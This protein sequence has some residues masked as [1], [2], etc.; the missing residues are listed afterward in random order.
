MARR[1]KTIIS[2]TPSIGDREPRKW[3]RKREEL[4]VESIHCRSLIF[5]ALLILTCML[6]VFLIVYILMYSFFQSGL[7][8][9]LIPAAILSG[10]AAYSLCA[11]GKVRTRKLLLGLTLLVILALTTYATWFV[12]TPNWVFGLRTDKSSYILGE[13]VQITVTLENHGF[14]PQLMTSPTANPVVVAVY[15]WHNDPF[16]NM[17]WYSPYFWNETTFSILPSQAL[18]RTFVWNQTNFVNPWLGNTTY[19]AGTYLIE[20]SIPKSSDFSSNL[21]SAD[22]YIN[23][24]AT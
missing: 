15:A 11:S 18:V 23:V 12:L 5:T 1:R 10:A 7:L 20:A 9:V 17:V 16:P 8:Y 19:K 2:R 14:V 22:V 4:L 21:F 13:S 3:S 24:T 6:A